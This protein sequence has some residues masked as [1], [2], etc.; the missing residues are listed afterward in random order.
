M[1]IIDLHCDTLSA[2]LSRN[3]SLWENNC[4][5]DVKRA[6]AAGVRL[7]FFALYSGMREYSPALRDCL[8]QAQSLL[9]TLEQFPQDMILVKS[10]EDLEELTKNDTRMGC[11]LHLEGG[12]ALG[13]DVEILHL[14][15]HLGLRS[16]GLTWNYRNQLANGVSEEDDRG[17]LS[18][19]G[20]E[21]VREMDGLGIALDLAHIA[22]ASFYDALDY[23]T[24]PPLVTHANAQALCPHRRNLDDS[25]LKALAER[26]GLIGVTYV[27]DFVAQT[28]PNVDQL[29]DHMVHISSLVGIHHL[30]LGSDFDGADDMVL[31]GVQELPA[32]VKRLPERGF[33]AEEIENILWKN[34]LRVLNAVLPAG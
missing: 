18:Q 24:R 32:L 20:K 1:N 19:K 14:F 22:P 17:G 3:H 12:E 4:H 34:A 26:D 33:T 11:L 6:R 21:V 9:Q 25:Q 27:N 29:I 13:M 2:I 31:S 10:G 16:L 8:V 15:H 7:Q 5:L 28:A 30:A 23:Y